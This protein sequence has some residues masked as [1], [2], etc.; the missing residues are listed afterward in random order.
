MTAYLG[1]RYVVGLPLLS[2]PFSSLSYVEIRRGEG[3]APL[4][5]ERGGTLLLYRL[6]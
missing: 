3:K 2:I 6:S 4:L 1:Y 5:R